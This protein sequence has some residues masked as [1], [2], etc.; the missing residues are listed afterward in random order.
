MTQDRD[1]IQRAV[2]RDGAKLLSINDKQVLGCKRTYAEF[3]CSCGTTAEKV[4]WGLIHVG[5]AFCKSCTNANIA[6]KRRDKKQAVQQVDPALELYL[7]SSDGDVRPVNLDSC[8]E[9]QVGPCYLRPSISNVLHRSGRGH[10]MR[11]VQWWDR[12]AMKRQARTFKSPEQDSEAELCHQDAVRTAP[13]TQI[14]S[15]S[16]QNLLLK[17]A[18]YQKHLK[19]RSSLSEFPETAVP[20][21]PYFL[22]IPAA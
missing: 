5:G 22:G 10:G 19:L 7:H 11:M 18:H 2:I 17:Q 6:R 15:M 1:V 9:L 3:T 13:S 12:D 16:V 8:I 21:E 20:L 14:V 4:S